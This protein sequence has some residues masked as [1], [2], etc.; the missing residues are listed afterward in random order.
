M[1][2]VID[3]EDLDAQVADA[4]EPYRKTMSADML[5][6]MRIVLRLTLQHHPDAAPLTNAT[7]RH[8]T[9]DESAEV[10]KDGEKPAAQ[11]G[12]KERASGD[13]E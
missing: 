12:K 2:G 9:V 10:A 1:I 8:K 5:E 4:L 13:D 3:E 7:V 6:K 11:T